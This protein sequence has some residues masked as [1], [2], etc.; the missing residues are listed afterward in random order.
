MKK[1]LPVIIAVVLI[2]VIVAITAGMKILERFSYSKERMDA[3]AYYGLETGEEVALV[4]NNEIKEEKGRLSEG[5]CYL[6]LDTVHAYLND[7]FYAD[8]NEG[9]LLYT[10]PDTIIR[11]E[12]GANGEEGYIPAFLDGGTM[13]VALDYV[14]KYTNFSFTLYQE[15]NRA[16]LTTSWSEHQAADIGKDTA[17]RYQGGVKSDILTDL[18]AGDKVVILE[19]MENWSKVATADGYLGYVENKRL[20]NR[21]SETLI[22]VTDYQEPEYTSIRR[23]YKINL[24]WHQVTSESANS[25]LE[26]VLDGISG[27]NVISPTWFFLSDDDGNFVS[28]GSTDYVNTAHSRGLEVW[29]LLDNFTYDVNTKEILS[30]TSKRAKLIEGLVNEALALGVDGINVDLEQV[31][32][33]AGEDYVEFLRELSIACRANNLVLS[34]DNYVPKNYNAH[35]NW[36]EQGVVADYVI[37]MGYDEHYGGSQEPGSVASIGYVEEGISTMVQSVP[38][39]K[40]INAVPFYTRIW[41]TVGGEVKSQAVGMSAVQNFL[42]ERNIEAVWDE[43]TCQNYGEV[44]DGDSFYQVWIEDARSLEVKMNIMKNYNLGGVAAWKLGYEKGHPEVWE[45]LSGFTNG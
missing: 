41:E 34:V 40:V 36:K 9:L 35:Y 30:Y 21:R 13:Y 20:E 1:K 4:L 45:V 32:S 37:I 5:R 7:R 17:V 3:N 16:V 23:D 19:E 8:Y 29:A 42:S 12:A 44:Q 14:K 43:T 10:T 22:P 39:E 27:M 28:I 15:P 31:S 24:G 33:D 25:T 26:S 6:P 2:I 18:S 38:S 11:A